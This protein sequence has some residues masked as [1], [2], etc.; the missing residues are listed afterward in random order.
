MSS[1]CDTLLVFLGVLGVAT[2]FIQFPAL[3]IALG[4]IGVGF[5]SFYGFAKLRE[6]KNGINISQDSKIAI[7]ARLAIMTS[8]GFS[9]LNPHVYL[10]TVVLIGGYSTKFDLISEG[11]AFGLGAS[12]L[13]TIW[14]FGLAVLASSGNRL[15]NDS[16]AMRLVS[17]ISGVILNIL[18][19]K[20][21]KDVFGWI[22]SIS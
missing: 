12:A 17:L 16:K 19:L 14:F 10:D 21:G 8:L 11:F 5:M 13:S 6:A 2:V 7:T 1:I 20:L 3:K 22:Q 9:F 4:I 15:L 18:A